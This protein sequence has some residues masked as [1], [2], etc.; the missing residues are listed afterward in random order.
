MHVAVLPVCC[1]F[2]ATSDRYPLSLH[3]A[4]PISARSPS[5]TSGIPWVPRT[6]VSP[7]LRRGRGLVVEVLE[8]DP[9][10][11]LPQR[12][13]DPVEL[14]LPLQSRKEDRRPLRLHPNHPADP[15]D[16]VRGDT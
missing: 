5:P 9:G 10:D 15:V 12:L 4:L 6:C 1:I 3:D 13:L 7:H 14:V 11:R 2:A 16:V 8:R